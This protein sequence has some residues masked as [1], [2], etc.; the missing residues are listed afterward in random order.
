MKI[1]KFAAIIAC[2]GFIGGWCISTGNAAE[3]RREAII[4]QQQ[5]KGLQQARMARVRT[6][7]IRDTAYT[8]KN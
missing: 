8:A 7:D 6:E 4:L 5:E 3:D 2:F 1:A